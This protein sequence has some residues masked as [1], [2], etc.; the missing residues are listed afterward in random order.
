MSNKS[1]YRKLSLALVFVLAFVLAV[2]A[3]PVTPLLETVY[4][5][6]NPTS[7]F[8]SFEATDDPV[9]ITDKLGNTE[10]ITAQP[11]GSY[12]GAG[13]SSAGTIRIA[14]DLMKCVAAVTQTSGGSLGSA[15]EDV[16]KLAD[17]NQSTKW[18][19][20]SAAAYTNSNNWAKYEMMQPYAATTYCLVG[21]NDN[22]S[23][24]SRRPYSWTVQGSNDNSN[25]TNL[26]QNTNGGFPTANYG[27]ITFTF[28][29]T[30]EYLYY[31]LVI[32]SLGTNGSTSA[33]ML[34]IADW[35][36]GT[37]VG[38]QV[39]PPVLPTT[40][41]MTI[42]A[43]SPS[44]KWNTVANNGWTGKRALGVAAKHTQ[45]GRVYGSAVIYEFGADEEIL[46]T[47]T[48]DLSYMVAPS[49]NELADAMNNEFGHYPSQHVSIDLRFTDG[50]YLSKLNCYDSHGVLMDPQSQFEGRCMWEG[51][52][53]KVLAR[54]GD[55]AAGKLIDQI[56]VSYDN[57]DGKN[58]W[59]FEAYFDDIR[60]TEKRSDDPTAQNF[61]LAFDATGKIIHPSELTDIRRGSN[62]SG[63]TFSRGN[64]GAD[65][66][67]PMGFNFWAPQTQVATND[68]Y[69][70]Q[71]RNNTTTNL[72]TLRGFD[73][74][75]RASRWINDFNTFVFLPNIEATL[76]SSTMATGTRGYP[77]SHNNEIAK[78]YY[79]S[80]VTNNN[81]KTELTP[82]NHGASARI[83]FPSDATYRNIFFDGVGTSA[84]SPGSYTAKDDEYTFS[85]NN[86]RNGSQ[87]EYV[88]IWFSETPTSKNTISG[89]NGAASY[90]RFA[91][92]VDTVEM[93][94]GTSYIS[95]EQAIKNCEME[96]KTTFDQTKA[97]AQ[98]EWDELM[99]RT[100]V[101]DF[102]P[103]GWDG[104]VDTLPLKTLDGLVTFYSN[105]Y[106]LC[107]WPTSGYE[108]TGDA[109]NPVYQYRTPYGGTV[110][111]GP[112]YF[113]N[114]FWDVYKATWSAYGL[115]YPKWSTL[116]LNGLVNHYMDSGFIPRWSAPAGTN[117]MVGTSS[118]IVLGTAAMRGLEFDIQRAFESAVK[119]ATVNN[120]SNLTN[121]GRDSLTTAI[122]YGYNPGT[123]SS[124]DKLS[125]GLESYI[126]DFGIAQMARKLGYTD[127]AAYYMARAVNY[128][129][130]W[131]PA[132]VTDIFSGD[133]ITGGWLRQ[134]AA[135]NATTGDASWAATFNPYA[136]LNG[137]TETNAWDMVVTV[138]DA[139]GLDNLLKNSGG[140][141]EQ[142]L[143]DVFTTTSSF[144]GGGYGI[145]HEGREHSAVKMGQY[146]HSNQPAHQ[147]P[148]FYN[149][150]DAPWKTQLYVRDI[151]DRLYTGW[152]VGYGYPGD[153]DNG[154]MSGT[155]VMSALGFGSTSLGWDE[156]YLTTPYFPH[157]TITRD[158]GSVVDIYAPGVSMTN[159]YIQSMKLNGVDYNKTYISSKDLYGAPYTKLE[160]V[161]GPQPGEWG[162]AADSK[163]NSITAPGVEPQPMVDLTKGYTNR[164]GD[165]II[166]GGGTFSS[167]A[168]LFNNSETAT[169]TATFA[170]GIWAGYRFAEPQVVHM[171]TISTGTTPAQNPRSW[172]FEASNDGTNWD[173]LDERTNVTFGFDTRAL[174]G[175]GTPVTKEQA[176]TQGTVW[177]ATGS[178]RGTE[179][180]SQSTMPFGIINNKAYT[181][182]RLRFT[183]T[184]GNAT[185]GISEIEFMG[186]ANP[187]EAYLVSA[188]D[189]QTNGTYRLSAAGVTSFDVN[190]PRMPVA[191]VKVTVSDKNGDY[192]ES[193]VF[194]PD[195]FSVKQSFAI[196]EGLKGAASAE[197]KISIE[198]E[199]PTF[200]TVFET[201]KYGGLAFDA[202]LDGAFAAGATITAKAKVS[203]L[204][205]Y[206]S[207]GIIA[208]FAMYN[209]KGQMVDHAIVNVAAMA[210]GENQEV[211]KTFEVPIGAAGYTVSVFFWDN[212]YIPLNEKTTFTQN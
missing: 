24:A 94:I 3:I 74:N 189:K 71:V 55:V 209:G 51:M 59:S 104:N 46:V 98:E 25:W 12:I 149:F 163:P 204:Q 173:I 151:L 134:K 206:A 165:A 139:Q 82:T 36:I 29:N 45:E 77:F 164:G 41:S 183:A 90:A 105:V 89:L 211:S 109:A 43:V 121:G 132:N 27:V 158:D 62:S 168:N 92:T 113:N 193:V 13:G 162:T 133:T 30:T 185:L 7:F 147:V 28:E 118:D 174:G 49:F 26:H 123:G 40:G 39:E 119:N 205:A 200:N 14:G 23:N 161:V 137:Y 144:Y 56:L 191:D 160:Y 108:N 170:S 156:F 190:L 61:D 180:N 22:S 44:I 38:D 210:S 95:I 212:D 194:T 88:Y 86:S 116:G 175:V 67:T 84:R 112:I 9:A 178:T 131:N 6:G 72:P 60:I 50:T 73:F 187:D 31:R 4:A 124:S 87:M 201:V 141:L 143:D 152:E 32:N 127:Q 150:T 111:N 76:T 35:S 83:T 202:S 42:S 159:K 125:W 138:S 5:A 167:D 182:Y 166:T 176:L 130:Y 171:Y 53:N 146:G 18:C 69:E 142:R 17:N 177:M 198:S 54:I 103:A 129:N 37:G 155:A 33:A 2:G 117:S 97:A 96:V 15:S 140:S 192:T 1:V 66:C 101:Q 172:V 79:Y 115:L 145:I 57:K 48:T 75:H 157:I 122:F 128:V 169:A 154:E 20:T 68:P 91:N 195:N 102:A 52:W 120:T 199:D 19:W 100:L 107:C 16:T 70:W 188:L 110:K 58:G 181:Q 114:G 203:N 179:T 47:P 208:I 63:G 197:L 64:Q 65:V 136:W 21:A 153:E 207:D 99:N 8:S 148:Y 81:I 34:Q 186:F 184:N 135:P 78:A 80:V 11:L 85:V 106:K 196:A 93:R 10:G 126:N